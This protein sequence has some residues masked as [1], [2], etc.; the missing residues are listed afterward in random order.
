MSE[1]MLLLRH[2]EL[3]NR[4]RRRSLQLLENDLLPHQEIRQRSLLLSQPLDASQS[5][6]SHFLTLHPVLLFN[7]DFRSGSRRGSSGHMPFADLSE[8]RDCLPAR[9]SLAA[10]V[11]LDGGGGG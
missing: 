1:R 10:H 5:L 11:L 9:R 6:Y 7:N 8:G 4:R 2:S 3:W